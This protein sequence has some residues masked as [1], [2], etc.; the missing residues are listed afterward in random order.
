[1]QTSRRDGTKA[2]QASAKTK[3]SSKNLQSQLTVERQRS[4]MRDKLSNYKK[5]S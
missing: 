1:M 3:A 5:A 4:K 2:P